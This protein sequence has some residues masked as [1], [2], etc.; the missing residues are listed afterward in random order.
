MRP[1][2]TN[3][4]ITCWNALEYTQATLRRL[5]E[6]VD[7][8][9]CLTIIDNGSRQNTRQ[10][11]QQLRSPKNCKALKVIYNKENMGPG[12]AVNQGFE[13][14]KELGMRFTCLCNNDLY[15]QTGWLAKLEAAA[16]TSNNMALVAPLRPATS[17]RYDTYTR[18]IDKIK[19]LKSYKTWQEE[20]EQYTEKPV[21]AFDDFA[22]NIVRVNGGGLVRVNSPPDALSSCCLLVRT[23]VFASEF[24]YIAD[25]RFTHYGSED[26]DI[27]WAVAARGY[28]CFLLKDV[29]IHHF[30]GKSLAENKLDR[31]ALI[32]N[33]NRIF[34]E[35]WKPFIYDFLIQEQDNGVDI[36]H[37]LAVDRGDKYWFLQR[38][39]RD[40]QFW[41]NGEIN[42]SKF[43]LSTNEAYKD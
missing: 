40:M 7:E 25:P 20:L 22:E 16:M 37:H 2:L 14:S 27:T 4:V 19:V 11:L 21:K 33:S 42:M 12:Y 8:E 34:F 24:G 38:L 3:I 41:I 10:Y 18:T 30:R 6:T 26:S 36:D 31:A 9:Y 35:K 15:F 32:I 1:P 29:Y 5:F 17:V 28:E 39:N 43:E 13:V 23:A